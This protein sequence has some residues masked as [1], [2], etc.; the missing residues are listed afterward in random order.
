ME[1]TGNFSAAENATLS[2][3]FLERL[4]K[5]EVDLALAKQDTKHQ[6]EL[7]D[8]KLKRLLL[9]PKKGMSTPMIMRP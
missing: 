8:L 7:V 1:N 6:L 2:S 9:K 3:E 5:A 4:I